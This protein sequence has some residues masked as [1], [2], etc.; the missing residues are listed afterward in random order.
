MLN[1]HVP[2]PFFQ[3]EDSRILCLGGSIQVSFSVNRSWNLEKASKHGGT[4]PWIYQR[5][6][7]YD[8]I[9]WA[10]RFGSNLSGGGISTACVGKLKHCSKGRPL[11]KGQLMILLTSDASASGFLVMVFHIYLRCS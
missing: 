10:A 8:A 7:A 2:K 9:E 5:V 3:F 1:G 4:P 11:D 6:K